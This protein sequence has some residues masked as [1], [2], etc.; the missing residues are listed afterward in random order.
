MRALIENPDAPYWFS[1][2]QLLPAAWFVWCYRRRKRKCTPDKI[3]NLT[4]DDFESTR[5]WRPRARTPAEVDEFTAYIESLV[6]MEA[7]SVNRYFNWKEG[8]QPSKLEVE[9][10]QRQIQN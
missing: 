7:N 2:A 3:I 10:I 5:G 9:W 8:K 6:D 1:L 4:L